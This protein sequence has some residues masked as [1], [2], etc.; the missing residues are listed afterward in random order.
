MIRFVAMLLNNSKLVSRT[1][2]N[3]GFTP[4]SGPYTQTARCYVWGFQ[5]KWTREKTGRTKDHVRDE[6]SHFGFCCTYRLQ[7]AG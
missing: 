2:S 6:R 1:V 5:R 4:I 7:R 3:R